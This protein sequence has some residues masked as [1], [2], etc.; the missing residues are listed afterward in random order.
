MTLQRN[1]LSEIL[2][3]ARFPPCEKG[4]QIII[5]FEWPMP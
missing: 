1:G 2:N 4:S 5:M 3:A